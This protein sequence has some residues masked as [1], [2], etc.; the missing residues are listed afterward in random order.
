GIWPDTPPG[1]AV[2]MS[3]HEVPSAVTH[4]GGGSA[5]ETG[6][7]ANA[8]AAAPAKNPEKIRV[9]IMC[10]AYPYRGV[11]KR[12]FPREQTQTRP[13]SVE[14]VRVCVCWA[15]KLRRNA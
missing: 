15:R 13:L 10:S 12:P 14:K 6:T 2:P 5:S 11:S 1:P 4:G 7:N 8:V 9:A 3:G